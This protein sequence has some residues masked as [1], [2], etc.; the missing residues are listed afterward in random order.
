MLLVVQ[1]SQ[2]TTILLKFPFSDYVFTACHCPPSVWA[3]NGA[4]TPPVQTP[5]WRIIRSS[6]LCCLERAMHCSIR[7]CKAWTLKWQKTGP[8]FI[9]CIF[10][11]VWMVMVAS[12]CLWEIWEIE[13]LLWTTNF[14]WC[15]ANQQAKSLPTSHNHNISFQYQSPCDLDPR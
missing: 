7:W 12:I 10:T 13:G 11:H 15:A 4:G 9:L 14:S 3:R 1:I 2:L 5:Y 8:A 6:A